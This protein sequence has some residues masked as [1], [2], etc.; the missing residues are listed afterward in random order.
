LP[1]EFIDN[2]LTLSIQKGLIERSNGRI[3]PTLL[4]QNFLNDLLQIFLRN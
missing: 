4:G 1:I 3:K 2:E